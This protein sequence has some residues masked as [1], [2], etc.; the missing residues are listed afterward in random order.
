MGRSLAQRL[1]AYGSPVAI[2]DIDER[3]LKETDASI[4][5]PVLSRVLDVRDADAQLSFA[6]EVRDWTPTV[7]AAV[8][9]NAGVNLASCSTP[10]PKTTNGCGTS[11]STAWSMEPGRFCRSSSS[12]TRERS[13]TPRASSALPAYATKV[14]IAQPSSRCVGSPMRYAR[15]CGAPG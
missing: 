1:T 8:F 12:R 11:T 2:T 4:S 7:V 5:G 13:S 10:I 3:G 15:N 6:D 14:P 9:N